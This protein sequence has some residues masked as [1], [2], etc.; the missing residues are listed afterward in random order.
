[1]WSKNVAEKYEKKN[2]TQE[3]W[4]ELRLFKTGMSPWKMSTVLISEKHKAHIPVL[5]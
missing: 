1:M 3:M 5:S 4:P 2:K